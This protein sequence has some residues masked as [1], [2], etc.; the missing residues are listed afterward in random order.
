MKPEKPTVGKSL[1]LQEY[2]TKLRSW[3]DK[4]QSL[5]DKAQNA[6]E[7]KAALVT[8]SFHL[9][10]MFLG[11]VPKTKWQAIVHDTCQQGGWADDH[12]AIHDE[13][14]GLSFDTLHLYQRKWLGAVLKKDAAEKQRA[15]L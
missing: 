6:A 5:Q 10:Q 15:Y 13:P 4:N 1:A 9:C 7:A 12:G 14:Q 11:V 2:E 8:K 3:T